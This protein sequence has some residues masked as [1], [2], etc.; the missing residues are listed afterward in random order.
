[1]HGGGAPR[2]P[3]STTSIHPETEPSNPQQVERS[4]ARLVTAPPEHERRVEGIAAALFLVAAIALVVLADPPA[5]QL[6]R[7]PCS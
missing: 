1:M 3:M 4:R 6:G 2:P 5:P 7:S